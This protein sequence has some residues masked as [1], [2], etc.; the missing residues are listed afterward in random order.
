MHIGFGKETTYGTAVAPTEFPDLISESL[1]VV[2]ASEQIKGI[3]RHSILKQRAH[4]S[5][6]E[7]DAR[8]VGNF[9]DLGLLL[10]SFFGTVTTTGAGPFTHTFPASTGLASR[11]GMSLTAEVRRE[12]ADALTWRYAGLKTVGFGFEADI[13]NS[14]KP[15]WSFIGKS[16][17]TGTAATDTAP[18]FDP[19]LSSDLLVSFD[20]TELND[21][22]MS[23]QASWPVTD[24]WKRRSELYAKEPRDSDVMIVEGTARVFLE[25]LTQYN[26]FA[27]QA[28][29]DV[30]LACSN[31]IESLTI[32]LNKCKITG[33]EAPREERN[34]LMATFAFAAQ[35]DTVATASMQA[36][37]VNDDTTIP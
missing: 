27:S 37:L 32:N 19:M 26:K 34:E 28:D 6:V 3:R 4:S 18:T 21:V 23:L 36:V 35:F 12:D 5:R 11:I 17:A 1:R 13:E 16:E 8:I 7:G 25:S 20:G 29:V 2:R 31:A 9:Q 33:I 30:Q 24:P 22:A 15:N 14:P 10:K